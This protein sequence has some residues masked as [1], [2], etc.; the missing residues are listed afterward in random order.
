MRPDAG[1]GNTGSPAGDDDVD[2][3]GVPTALAANRASSGPLRERIYN[4]AIM[5]V[6]QYLLERRSELTRKVPLASLIAPPDTEKGARFPVHPG[7]AAYLGDT[8]TS[9]LTLVSDQFWNVM[10]VGGML[11]SLLAASGSF[12]KHGG[13][14]ECERS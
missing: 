6:T 2:T 7:A 1:E 14:I 12:L 3:V 4:N 10:L 8:V 11:T 9:F 13:P 5:D